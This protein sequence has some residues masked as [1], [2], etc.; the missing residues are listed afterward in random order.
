MILQG[1][2]LIV[3][4]VGGGLGTEMTRAALRDGARVVIG[5]RTESVLEDT[6]NELEPS[7]ERIAW[8]RCDITNSEDCEALVALALERFGAVHA[9]LQVAA[10]EAAFGEVEQADLEHWR[11]SFETNVLGAVNLVRAVAP[12][13]RKTGGGSIVMVG[14][15]SSLLPQLPQAGYA[16]S[17]AALH[18]AVYYLTRELGPDKIRVNQVVPSWMWGPPVEGFVKMQAKLEKRSEQEIKDEITS[19][20]PLGRIVPDEDVAEAAIFLAS[21]RARSITGQSLLVNGGELMT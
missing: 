9:L 21:D 11:R 4:G 5:A 6:A 19:R 18:S 1:K 3:S 12:A 10:Y 8:R 17:K 20:I 2:T 16:A 7:G 14:S 13:M 15:Q